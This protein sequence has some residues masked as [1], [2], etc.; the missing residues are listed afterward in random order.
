MP[1]NLVFGKKGATQIPPIRGEM[2]GILKIN[3]LG[4][5][6]KRALS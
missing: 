5:K 4:L 6:Q 1:I 2:T 3:R